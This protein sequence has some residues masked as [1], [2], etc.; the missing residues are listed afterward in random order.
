MSESL[1]PHVVQH[2]RLPCLSPSSRLCSNS[3]PLS[4]WCHPTILSSIIL[5]SSCFQS[6]PAS[7][8]FPMSR[9]FASD[10]QSIGALV[11]VLPMNIQGLF[12]L[13]LPDLISLQSKGLSR[14]F[15]STIW[16]HQFSS[17]QPSSW[18]SFHICT[19][20]LEKPWLW[21]YESLSAKRCLCFLICCLG[22]S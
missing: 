3:C 9:L 15:S 20:L 1:Q 6:F 8:F 14:I 13:G 2:N 21:L 18:Y 17:T 12:P 19:W 10:D 16:K 7:G 22:L 11:S 5:F 4:W